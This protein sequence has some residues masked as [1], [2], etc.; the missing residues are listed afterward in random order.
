MQFIISSST[1]IYAQIRVNISKKCFEAVLELTISILIAVHSPL[2]CG[3]QCSVRN[4]FMYVHIYL[5]V[6]DKE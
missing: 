1:T 5:E 2:R 3:G 6:A 4:A